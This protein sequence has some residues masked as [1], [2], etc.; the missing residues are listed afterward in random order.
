MAQ[1]I[2]H[3]AESMLCNDNVDHAFEAQYVKDDIVD[4]EV[5]RNR[6]MVVDVGMLRKSLHSLCKI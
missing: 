4:P 6:D 2:G 1:A 3:A 5:V